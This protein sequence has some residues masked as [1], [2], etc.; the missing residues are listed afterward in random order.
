MR[1]TEDASSGV[2]VIR[3]YAA[4]EIRINEQSIRDGVIVSATD[5]IVDPGLRSVADLSAEHH[6]RALSLEPELVLVGSGMRQRFPEAGFGARYLSL[7]IGFE[8]MDTG[9][10]C[11]TFNV[12]VAERRRVVALLVL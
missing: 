3:G 6:A 12:L 5:L 11:R 1:F 7:G 2:N 4:G 8:V 10:A 9:A